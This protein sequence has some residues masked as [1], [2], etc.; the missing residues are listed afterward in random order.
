MARQRTFIKKQD[1][2][3][4]VR[5]FVWN[6]KIASVFPDFSFESVMSMIDNDPIARGAV[7]HFVDKCMEGD[8]N[9]IDRKS[10]SYK[11]EEEL[12]L[13]EKYQFR[14][15]FM[16]KTF[17]IGKLYNNAFWEIVKGIENT[18]LYLNVLDSAN[19]EPITKPNGDPIS[20]RTKLP[21]PTTGQY[22]TWDK[23]EIVWVKFNDRSQGYAPVDLKALYETLCTKEFIRR[24]I[25]WLWKT[26]QYR[27][28][29]NF[30]G[31]VDKQSIEDFIA[32]N[33]K[34]DD[35]FKSPFL[36]KGDMEVMSVR[37]I[38]ET[39][40]IVELLKY[41][42]SQILV[43]LRVPPIDAGIVDASG[44]SNSDAQNNSMLAHV[45]SYKS[46]VEDKINF[47]LFPKI[48]KSTLLIRFAPT[49]RFAEKQ[50]F[51][52]VQIMQSVGM[53]P[54]AIEEYMQDR[55]LYYK[56]KLFKDPED[57]MLAPGGSENPRD[58]DKFP[59]R[60]TKGEGEGEQ[61]IG[62][63]NESSTREDQ[64]RKV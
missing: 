39:S 28:L 9:I 8:Y 19:I 33:S 27:V 38:Q 26:G 4:V 2:K 50:V 3:D 52:V 5:N 53:T 31:S 40:F 1:S 12:R 41:L 13:D 18:T 35:N 44:R 56:S 54:E 48:N 60:Q 49:D 23:D 43:L 32:Y 16:R 20:Y 62:S 59:S 17:L 24:Y 11:P 51:E 47:E 63:G 45:N 61:K 29:Y 57:M 34:H 6:T 21:D 55:G 10:R 58:K 30:K 22:A 64:L 36:M 37:S 46:I 14:T 7:L 42:D 15:N 25:A